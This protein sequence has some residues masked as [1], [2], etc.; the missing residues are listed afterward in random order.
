MS[1]DND[2]G[3]DD[4]DDGTGGSEDRVNEKSAR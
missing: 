2:D 3:S 1:L 4:G